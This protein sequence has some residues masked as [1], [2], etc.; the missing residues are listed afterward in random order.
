MQAR[1]IAEEISQSPQSLAQFVCGY[2]GGFAIP[3]SVLRSPASPKLYTSS[4]GV[5]RANHCQFSCC[6]VQPLTSTAGGDLAASTPLVYLN[7]SH[8]ILHLSK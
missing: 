1:L 7:G 6:F 3:V 5:N 8:A 4:I 2:L